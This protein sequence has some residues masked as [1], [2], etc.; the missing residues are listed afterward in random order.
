MKQ[1]SNEVTKVPMCTN[2]MGY[3]V[4]LLQPVFEM[5]A[6]VSWLCTLVMRYMFLQTKCLLFMCGYDQVYF[7]MHTLYQSQ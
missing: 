6:H 5:P 7:R 3:A 2:T 1:M 4:D